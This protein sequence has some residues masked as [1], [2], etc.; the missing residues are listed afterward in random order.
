MLGCGEF[1]AE[2]SRAPFSAASH[3]DTHAQLESGSWAV[4]S[5]G[6]A[7]DP[8]R[9]GVLWVVWLGV[10]AG[11]TASGGHGARI[12]APPGPSLLPRSCQAP[13]ARKSLKRAQSRW[14]FL[15]GVDFSWGG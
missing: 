5:A 11:S 4:P 1:R 12:T 13:N 3:H 9:G 14:F 7:Q 6:T 10:G 2:R 8:G 15:A